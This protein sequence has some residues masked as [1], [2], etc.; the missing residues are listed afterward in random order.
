PFPVGVTTI[1]FYDHSRVDPHTMKA[2]RALKTEIWYPATDGSRTLPRNKF[3]DFLDRGSSPLLA[4][5]ASAAFG[6]P[7]ADLDARFKDDAVRDARGRDGLFPL[8]LF[9]HGNGSLRTQSVFWC[10]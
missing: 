4:A 6:A 2:P 3:S 7:V 8:L 5:L 1:V 9:S 10:E